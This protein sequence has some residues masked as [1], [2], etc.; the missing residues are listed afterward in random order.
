MRLP[1]KYGL[2]LPLADLFFWGTDKAHPEDIK[3]AIA[4]VPS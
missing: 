2:E 4:I 3:A 1:K